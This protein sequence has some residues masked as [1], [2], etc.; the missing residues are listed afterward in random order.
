MLLRLIHFGRFIMLVLKNL[1]GDI[2]RGLMEIESLHCKDG[3]IILF[4][5]GERAAKDSRSPRALSACV[6]RHRN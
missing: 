4:S 5:D 2:F 1:E 3:P 6:I